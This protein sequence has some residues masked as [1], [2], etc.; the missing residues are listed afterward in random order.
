MIPIPTSRY[1]IDAEVAKLILGKE[2]DAY[3]KWSQQYRQNKAKIY[4]V[5]LGQCT[6]ATKNCLEGKETFEDINGESD[7]IRL[8]LLIKSIVY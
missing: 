8:L 5:A 4:S 2:I 1:D 6:E 3:V 7:A